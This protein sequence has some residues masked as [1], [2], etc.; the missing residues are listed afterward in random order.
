MSAQH[1]PGPWKHATNLGCKAIKGD[2]SGPHRQ[3]QRREVAY[4]SGIPDEVEDEA[5]ARLI[6]AAPD[7]HALLIEAIESLER[8]EFKHVEDATVA[9]DLRQ[10]IAA[11]TARQE[12][13]S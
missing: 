12:P 9:L 2:K 4:T 11:L 6:A 10:R 5:N 3:A 13:R 8:A 1:T 7:M